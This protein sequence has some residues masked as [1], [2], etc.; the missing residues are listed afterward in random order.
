MEAGAAAARHLDNVRVLLTGRTWQSRR[1]IRRHRTSSQAE[2]TNQNRSC[3]AH[4][5]FLH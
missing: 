2:S 5:D 3:H 1:G 4:V